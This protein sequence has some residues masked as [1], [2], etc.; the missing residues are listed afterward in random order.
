MKN[1]NL[2][3]VA[4]IKT[5]AETERRQKND[6]RLN[7]EDRRTDPR[8]GLEVKAFVSMPPLTCRGLQ[9]RDISRSGMYLAFKD[10]GS[11]LFELKRAGIETGTK[12]EIAFAVYL[13]EKR[14][15]FSIHARLARIT[16]KGLGFEFLTHNPPQLSA[17]RELFSTAE[18]EV[19]A[20]D[21]YNAVAFPNDNQRVIQKPSDKSGWED[22]EILE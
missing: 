22:W 1:K 15:G 4:P 20:P 18:R 12:A 2:D 19:S 11:T 17:L 6:R 14:H 8:I 10:A 13:S 21:Q 16:Q 7:A 5:T 3:Y 9:I